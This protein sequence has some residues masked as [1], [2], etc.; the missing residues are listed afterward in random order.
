MFIPVSTQL[1]D[2]SANC[3]VSRSGTLIA[4]CH[5][6][7][8]GTTH[9]PLSEIAVA[10]GDAIVLHTTAE[11]SKDVQVLINADDYTW[12][13]REIKPTYYLLPGGVQNLSGTIRAPLKFADGTTRNLVA[14][15]PSSD[16]GPIATYMEPVAKSIIAVNI[17][18]GKFAV[19]SVSETPISMTTV[20]AMA[21]SGYEEPMVVVLTANK[22]YIFTM[23]MQLVKSRD[24]TKHSVIGANQQVT[25]VFPYSGDSFA[26]TYDNTYLFA[27]ENLDGHI[28]T[29]YGPSLVST[30]G[31]T[32]TPFTFPS[33]EIYW[34]TVTGIVLHNTVT[35]YNNLELNWVIA[36]VTASSKLV[37]SG[38]GRW[39]F[40]ADQETSTLSVVDRFYHLNS[41]TATAKYQISLADVVSDIEAVTV[42]GQVRLY[43]SYFNRTGVDCFNERLELIETL[44]LGKA[45]FLTSVD[46]VL[47][48]T[49]VYT[50]P[51]A[52]TAVIPEEV[53]VLTEEQKFNTAKVITY[54]HTASR[55]L[56][57][58]A[59]S[60]DVVIKVNGQPFNGVLPPSATVTIEL[61]ADD[62]YYR[63]RTFG[64][65]GTKS[66]IFNVNVEPRLFSDL[67]TLASIYAAELRTD[68]IEEA[69][70][71]G[72]T[73]GF[74]VEVSTNN[75]LM[76]MSVNGGEFSRTGVV[77]HGDVITTKWRLDRLA[78]VY[79]T[80]DNNIDTEHG[81]TI[82]TWPILKMELE[83]V[84]K[85]EISVDVKVKHFDYEE[86]VRIIESGGVEPEVN[87]APVIKPVAVEGTAFSDYSSMFSHSLACDACVPAAITD[88]GVDGY[89]VRRPV[90]YGSA[91]YSTPDLFVSAQTF[92]ESDIGNA[93]RVASPYYGFEL[94]NGLRL[95]SPYYGFDI[96]NGLRLASPSFDF[97]ID[98]ATRRA[99]SVFDSAPSTGVLLPT[100][101]AFMDAYTVE[102]VREV[103]RNGI[104]VQLIPVKAVGNR[105]Y[106][107]DTNWM[108][109]TNLHREP[110]EP[111]YERRDLRTV[112]WSLPEYEQR[113]AHFT[114]N[115]DVPS[116]FAQL[117]SVYLSD[118][119]YGYRESTGY[120]AI[121]IVGEPRGSL[122]YTEVELESE[123]NEKSKL[124]EID[125]VSEFLGSTVRVQI[126]AEVDHQASTTRKVV[127]LESG[128]HPGASRAVVSAA[129]EM[130]SSQYRSVTLGN[131]G[132]FATREAAETYATSLNL[133]TAPSIV[134]LG[135]VWLVISQPVL[136]GREC[137]PGQLQLPDK[138]FGYL[139]GG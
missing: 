89:A 37:L 11:E 30:K 17:E 3:V 109:V 38:A 104:T 99:P 71:Q 112:K 136:S 127:E 8:K 128:L 51:N 6:T 27:I 126:E 88:A 132:L 82:V 120:H 96:G 67:V 12:H 32:G 118:I 20:P 22:L 54:Q 13:I 41:G 102:A 92:G 134:Q 49:A 123:M 70:V 76:L 46:D 133:E 122:Y 119:G 130:R 78:S 62:V 10:F 14:G 29:Q 74:T 80:V 56:S 93:V 108:E 63:H 26:Y 115:I 81:V 65:V 94:G 131:D 77:K 19:G 52:V 105:E 106:M 47:V 43:V 33:G 59:L 45:V 2:V 121:G 60:D 73:E 42:D 117:R 53:V 95:A 83:G 18:T 24:V 86:Q 100:R 4:E 91:D 15:V 69:L 110:I 31:G 139:G 116:E 36:G 107:I 84:D 124:Y 5:V 135:A 113:L 138:T 9:P 129:V 55:A 111:D 39:V 87:Y 21:A 98:S 61:P 97:D 125:T 101:T 103:E 23:D 64:L 68:Y 7:H 34:P 75:D 48:S 85:S 72:I 137:E 28:C 50:N 90:A 40:A 16:P 58:E 44:D 57:A 79:Y 114:V 25:S 66:I 35:A 1:G